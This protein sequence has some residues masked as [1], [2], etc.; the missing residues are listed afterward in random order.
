MVRNNYELSSEGSIRHWEVP[1]ARL[2]NATPTENEPCM[3]LSVIPGT[4]VG[5]TILSVDATDSIA[6]VDFTNSMVY[7]HAVRN[8][9]TYGAGPAEATW[10]PINIG[11]PIFY[12]R[13]AIMPANVFLSTSPLDALGV[14]NARFGV[15]VLAEGI[16]AAYPYGNALAGS[17]HDIAVMQ[18]GAAGV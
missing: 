8:V 2:E 14:A 3:M 12:D 9:L 17:T 11:D 6:I 5:G 4:Q 13:S 15:A 16:I 7:R 18:H 1:Y 10:G